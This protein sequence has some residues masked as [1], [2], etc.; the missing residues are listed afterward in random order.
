MKP[1]FHLNPP[2]SARGDQKPPKVEDSAGQAVRVQLTKLEEI[3]EYLKVLY[4]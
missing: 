4:R 2:T 3:L 1:G